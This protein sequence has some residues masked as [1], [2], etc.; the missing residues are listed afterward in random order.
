MNKQEWMKKALQAGIEEVEIF[1]TQAKCKTINLFEGKVDNYKISID[2]NYLIKATINKKLGICNCANLDEENADKVIQGLVESAHLIESADEVNFYEGEKEYPSVR[3]RENR[4]KYHSY[5]TKV[6]L[7]KEI[8]RRCFQADGRVRQV[9]DVELAEI[10]NTTS[11]VNS[12]GLNLQRVEDYA[13]VAVSLLASE[14]KDQKSG[15]HADFIV[16]DSFDVERF[17]DKVVKDTVNKLNAKP[18]SSAVYPTIIHREAMRSLLAAFKGLFVGE[19]VYKGISLLK[20]KIGEQ[21]FSEKINIVDDA[22]IDYQFNSVAFDDEG[23]SGKRKV[24]VENGILKGYLHNLKSATMMNAESTGNGFGGGTGTTNFAITNGNIAYDALIK[25]MDKGII[26]TDISGLHAGIN[27]MTTQFSLLASGYLV[28][29]G[30]IVKP[31]NLITIAGVF[32][33]MMR[34]VVAVGDDL[35]YGLSGVGAPSILFKG[36]AISG[37]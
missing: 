13:L 6:D 7:L 14:E 35:E 30:E 25:Q 23:V 10:E 8:E 31:V 26:I 28:E 33:D 12:K 27:T 9:M 21:I 36:C 22:L 20:D 37:E 1:E 18:V 16:D 2:Q 17:V 4:F 3:M 34:E 32:M 11:I 24:L 29:N 15:Y 5:E 19:N